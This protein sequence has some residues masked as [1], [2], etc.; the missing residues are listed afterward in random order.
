MSKIKSLFQMKKLKLLEQEKELLLQGLEMVNSAHDW[1]EDRLKKIKEKQHNLALNDAANVRQFSLEL[2]YFCKHSIFCFP[3][4]L[5]HDTFTLHF[6]VMKH[7]LCHLLR[8]V[9]GS[10]R[11]SAQRKSQPADGSNSRAQ[12]TAE[13]FDRK[14]PEGTCNGRGDLPRS[15]VVIFQKVFFSIV[16][17]LC[18]TY[19]G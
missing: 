13:G 9:I 11:R 16:H 5:T 7:Q 1:Y 14:S 17:Y 8:A 19:T 15:C 10:N 6:C 3:F 4:T 18:C 12:S 2:R